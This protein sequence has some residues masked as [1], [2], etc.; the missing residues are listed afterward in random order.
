MFKVKLSNLFLN[1][2]VMHKVC[3]ATFHIHL[4]YATRLDLQRAYK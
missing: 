1:L 2:R 4:H 3:T